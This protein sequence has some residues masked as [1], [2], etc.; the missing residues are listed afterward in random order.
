MELENQLA[1]AEEIVMAAPHFTEGMSFFVKEKRYNIKYLNV[2]KIRVTL[3][4]LGHITGVIYFILGHLEVWGISWIDGMFVCFAMFI[5]VRIAGSR[6]QMKFFYPT[7]V[8]KELE[9]CSTAFISVMRNMSQEQL[10]NFLVRQIKLE[11]NQNYLSLIPEFVK[12]LYAVMP[13]RKSMMISVDELSEVVENS[14]I[15]VAKQ[16]RGQ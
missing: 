15:E 10:E 6:K 9:E 14:E 3:Q 12:Y 16:L 5:L 7:D 8:S 13:D 11:E 4:L 1:S 2:E